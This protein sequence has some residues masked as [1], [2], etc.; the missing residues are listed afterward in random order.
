MAD[1]AANPDTLRQLDRLIWILIGMV[2]A[3]VMLAPL[4]STFSI[5]WRSFGPGI[6]TCIGLTAGA[7]YYRHWRDDERLASGLQCC[8]QLVAFAAVAAPLS[9]LA[10]GL[11]AAVPL[12]DPLLDAIDK[13]LGFDWMALLRWFNDAS[14]AFAGLRL[15]YGSL[16]PQMA[17]AVLCLAFTGRTVWL[18]TIVLAFIFTTIVTI[19]ISAALPAAGVWL[20]YGL[21]EADATTI[22]VVRTVWPVFTGQ[23]DGSVRDLVGLGAEGVITFPSLHAALAVIMIAALWPIAALRWPVLALDAAMLLST[24]VD[25]AHYLADVLAGIC[26]AVA[27][28]F[29]ARAMTKQKRFAKSLLIAGETPQLAARD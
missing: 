10:A 29:S 9:Y 24:P 28:I 16:L 7:W 8:A 20:H 5:Q 27:C 19:A 4:I 11:G 1:R 23:R 22:P 18:R 13:A 15:A 6:A 3:T 21:T 26:I 17:I 12:Q 2:G 25:G 14:V